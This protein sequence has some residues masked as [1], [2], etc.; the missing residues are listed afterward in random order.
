MQEE[1]KTIATR[2]D[3]DVIDTWLE[4]HKGPIGQAREELEA[5][6]A[7]FRDMSDYDIQRDAEV[8]ILDHIAKL[9]EELNKV[10]LKASNAIR[11]IEEK[12]AKL[13][14]LLRGDELTLTESLAV[15]RD[16]LRSGSDIL[17]AQ[18]DRDLKKP[19]A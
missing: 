2:S 10:K 8:K 4:A 14:A 5:A 18:L 12:Q 13:D 6:H 19:G 11:K 15:R 9:E 3:S 1:E 16:S 7:E 17:A